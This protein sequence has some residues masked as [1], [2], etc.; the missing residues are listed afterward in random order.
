[1]QQLP[2]HIVNAFVH[3]GHGG[4]PAGVVIDADPLDRAQKQAIAARV[5]LSETAFVSRSTVAAFKLE[6][7]TPTR[8]I[9]HCGHATIAT[10]SYL[11]ALGRVSGAQSSKETIDGTRKILF[12]GE[13]VFMEQMAPRY[14]ALTEDE[15]QRL[16]NA[17]GV[18]AGELLPGAP[19]LGVNTG[20]LFIVV[21]L[22]DESVLGS[23]RPAFAEVQSVV[24][25]H[26]GIGVYPFALGPGSDTGDFDAV[27]RMFAP[28]YGIPEEA[29]TGMA[30]GPLA[31]YLRD[32]LEDCLELGQ[33][34]FRISQGRFM[35][36]SS[37]S[38]IVVRLRE[39]QTGAITGLVAGG[40]GKLI[41]S[42]SVTF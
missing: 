1:M 31:C 17:L 23:L 37:P 8:Q 27:A 21:P 34:E 9:P 15:T 41:E 36:P 3:H 33:T 42:R 38:E 26:G 10:F 28:S 22:R 2:V 19:V 16:L 29:A 6:F 30:A 4:N 18:T 14:E 40:Q 25:A 13:R 32:Q 5:G 12:E 7:F 20:N 35:Q 24:D 39:D 11:Q